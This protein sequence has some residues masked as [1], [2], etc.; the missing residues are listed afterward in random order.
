MENAE[1]SKVKKNPNTGLLHVTPTNLHKN[2][3]T[4]TAG[5]MKCMIRVKAEVEVLFIYL[6]ADKNVFNNI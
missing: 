4:Q 5:S 1:S 2:S 6:Y 3:R